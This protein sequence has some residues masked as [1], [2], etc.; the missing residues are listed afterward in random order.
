MIRS[1]SG[2]RGGGRE[3]LGIYERDVSV[4]IKG[5]GQRR[6]VKILGAARNSEALTSA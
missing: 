6:G 3:A 5:E 2:K 4:D 1:P